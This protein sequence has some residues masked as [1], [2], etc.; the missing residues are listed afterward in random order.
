MGQ[1]GPRG[2]ICPG[3]VGQHTPYKARAVI[4]NAMIYRNDG[5]IC[6]LF[7]FFSLSL[8]FFF[9]FFLFFFLSLFFFFFFLSFFPLSFFKGVGGMGPVHTV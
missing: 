2:Q 5:E 4:I 3:G 9:F 6:S 8:F 1:V 7:F